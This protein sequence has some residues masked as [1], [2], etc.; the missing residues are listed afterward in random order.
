LELE[1]G[2]GGLAYVYR[3]KK[4]HHLIYFH[5]HKLL[6]EE[7]LELEWEQLELEHRK[8]FGQGL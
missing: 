7:V 6:Q 8:D 1:V 3:Q 5:S 2:V 4:F